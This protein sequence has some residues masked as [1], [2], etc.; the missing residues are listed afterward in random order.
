VTPVQLGH[1]ERVHKNVVDDEV[2]DVT[3]QFD[4]DEPR[5]GDFDLGQVAVVDLAPLKSAS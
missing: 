2:V 3:G 4:V 1:H 5:V